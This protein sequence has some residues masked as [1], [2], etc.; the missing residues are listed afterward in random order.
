MVDGDGVNKLEGL[1]GDDKIWGLESA[2]MTIGKPGTDL[3]VGGACNGRYLYSA[4]D[5]SDD[6]SEAAEGGD[7]DLLEVVQSDADVQFSRFGDNLRISINGAETI[8]VWDQFLQASSVRLETLVI[9]QSRPILLE[10][11]ASIT[12]EPWQ[13]MLATLSRR[14]SC[15]T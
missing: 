15:A 8:V 7:N 2:D 11:G 13:H 9:G 5:G 12:D 3:L 14:L 6:I 10:T 1:A 4:C